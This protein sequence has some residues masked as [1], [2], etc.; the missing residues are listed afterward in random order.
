VYRERGEG[1]DESEARD[2]DREAAVGRGQGIRSG[3]EWVHDSRKCF[4]RNSGF[5]LEHCDFRNQ[6]RLRVDE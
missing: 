2:R 4:Y 5:L 6:Y 1:E 3:I